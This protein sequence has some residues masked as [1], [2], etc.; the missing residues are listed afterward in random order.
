MGHE[1]LAFE[2]CA[3]DKV[4]Q[5]TNCCAGEKRGASKP[6]NV[7]MRTSHVQLGDRCGE[8]GREAGKLGARNGTGVVQVEVSHKEQ[9]HLHSTGISAL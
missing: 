5:A 7:S 2:L 1:D 8:R 9:V 6:N 4:P 3:V